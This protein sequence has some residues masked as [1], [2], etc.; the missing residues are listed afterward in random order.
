MFVSPSTFTLCKYKDIL[1]RIKTSHKSLE[2]KNFNIFLSFSFILDS[3]ISSHSQYLWLLRPSFC[4]ATPHRT[5]FLLCFLS[6]RKLFTFLLTRE[7]AWETL[8]LIVKNNFF[9]I[10]IVNFSNNVS[11]I[12]LGFLIYLLTTKF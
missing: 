4:V 10:W 11:F 7:K 9:V 2:K 6:L 1:I 12:F 5:L 8:I 3:E